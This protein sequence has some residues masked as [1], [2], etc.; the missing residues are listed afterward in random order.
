MRVA[1]LAAL[2]CGAVLAAGCGRTQGAGADASDLVPATAPA[3]VAVDTDPSSSQWR[4]VDDLASRFPD[5]QKGV[6]AL[7]REL[8]NQDHLDWDRDVKPALGKEIDFVWLDLDN[9]GQ[10]FVLLT[11]PNDEGKFKQLIAKANA[12]DPSSKVVHEKVQGWEVLAE[13]QSMLDR[14]QRERGAA[15]RTLADEP[16]F[17][18]SMDRLGSNAVVRAYVSGAEIMHLVRRSAGRG[19]RPF[20][21]K[22]GSLDWIALKLGATADGISFDTIVHGTPGT[23]FKGL[24]PSRTFAP[25]LTRSTPQDALVYLTFHGSKNLFTN[26]QQNPVFETPELRRFSGVLRQLG[27]LLQGENAFYVR[28]AAGRLPEVTFVA[29]PGKGIDGAATVDRLLARFHRDLQL[30]PRRT[31]VAGTPARKLGFGE[32]GAYYA[33]VD[34]KL[35]ITDLPAGIRGVRQP[36]K[37]LTESDVYRDASDASGLPGKTQGFLYVNIHS[38]IPFV[39]KLS[40]ARLP[41]ELSRNLKP[42]RSAVEY[43][44][45]HSHEIQVTFFLR[46]K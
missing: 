19:E 6:D 29:A 34:G 28:P 3:F 25:K 24:S 21:D 10:D 42:L 4:M 32:F 17:R 39:E 37:P 45:T 44:V 36:G 7:K 12:S 38:T 18:H 2:V 41:A 14:F 13:K 26:L 43:A 23:L 46:I 1:G 27:T 11:Q 35:V 16:A 31:S 15:P 40:Q 33:N 22:A 30:T 5:K 9:N 20:L 8:K